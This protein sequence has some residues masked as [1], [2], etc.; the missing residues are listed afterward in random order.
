MNIFLSDNARIR[1]MDPQE[2]NSSFHSTEDGEQFI[3]IAE[4]RYLAASN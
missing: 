2:T 4:D 3:N 1:P